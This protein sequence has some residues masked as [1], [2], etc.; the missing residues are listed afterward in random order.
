MAGFREGDGVFHGFRVADFA[1]EN[2]VRRLTQCIFQ[3]VM[4]SVGV[5]ADFTVRDERH[6]G[7]MHIF[8]R[9][10]DRDDVAGRGAIALIDHRRQ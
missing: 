5:D 8:H 6:L 9:V 2:H 4:P 10:F 7:F 3:R 1:D